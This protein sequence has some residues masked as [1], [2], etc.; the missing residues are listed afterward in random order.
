MPDGPLFSLA[1]E[2]N[3]A[4]LLITGNTIYDANSLSAGLQDIY[5]ATRTGPP[6]GATTTVQTG[7]NGGNSAAAIAFLNANNTLN[8]P[9]KTFDESGTVTTVASC[10]SF[11][12]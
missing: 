1:D 7:V 4:C 5:L 3:S 8:G 9:N 12:P 10:G 2:H 6:A 11:P